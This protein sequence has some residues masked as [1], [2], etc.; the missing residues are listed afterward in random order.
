MLWQKK[1]YGIKLS[2]GRGQIITD[3]MFGIIQQ[4]TVVPEHKDTVWSIVVK[5]KHGDIIYQKTDM[6]GRMDDRQGLP[7]G[8][9]TPEQ[10]TVIIHD[11]T[12][13]EKFNIMFKV[14]EA[15]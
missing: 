5:D 9:D 4:F 2:H 6:E 11:T 12:S 7:V 14:R 3:S 8:Q 13:N 1:T 10:L 15:I